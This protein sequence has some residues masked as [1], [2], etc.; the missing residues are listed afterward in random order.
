MNIWDTALPH[1]NP[2]INK[3]VIIKPPLAQLDYYQTYDRAGN[4]IHCDPVPIDGVLVG[5]FVESY[6]LD[7]AVLVDRLHPIKKECF[8][9]LSWAV[10]NSG[11]GIQI[12][13]K[14]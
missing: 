7:S 11:G 9:L 12:I 8:D 1:L 10:G 3:P 4:K 13:S 2:D 6:N 14:L 5:G